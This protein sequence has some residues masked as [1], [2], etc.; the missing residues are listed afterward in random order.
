MMPTQQ[1]KAQYLQEQIRALK[2]TEEF[3]QT[4]MADLQLEIAKSNSK[5]DS[6]TEALFRVTQYGVDL[7]NTLDS[8]IRV[9]TDSKTIE[10]T[11][12]LKKEIQKA[13]VVLGNE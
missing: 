3:N 10:P 8:L 12:L 9:I 11:G 5:L 7:E 4:I 13:K 2:F 1:A 6:V